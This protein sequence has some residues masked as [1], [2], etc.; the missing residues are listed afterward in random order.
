MNSC[1]LWKS[2]DVHLFSVLFVSGVVPGGAR[3]STAVKSSDMTVRKPNLQFLWRGLQRSKMKFM[4]R[5]FWQPRFS[6]QYID[7]GKVCQQSKSKIPLFFFSVYLFIL[8]ET[9]WAGQEKGEKERERESQ[10]GSVLLGWSLMQG[11]NSWTVKLWPD[12]NPRVG[13]L[14]DWAPQMPQ[15]DTIIIPVL[16]KWAGKWAAARSMLCSLSLLEKTSNLG[17]QFLHHLRVFSTNSIS[18][19][20]QK[21]SLVY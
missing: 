15:E 6:S 8:K 17:F 13:R 7:L 1:V 3:A 16:Y 21:L 19:Y 11:L 20:N 4:C 10:A 18:T 14:M 5:G 12:L 2:V 9:A